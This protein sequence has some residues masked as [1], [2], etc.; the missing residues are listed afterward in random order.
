MLF[1]GLSCFP[2]IPLAFDPKMVRILSFIFTFYFLSYLSEGLVS[3]SNLYSREHG[4][5]GE[6][7][8]KG[9]FLSEAHASKYNQV[10]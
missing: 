8:K 9:I 6:R 10:F 7:L 5:D 1:F 3:A 2:K 4:W